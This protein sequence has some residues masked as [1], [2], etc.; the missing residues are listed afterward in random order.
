MIWVPMG[1][2][3]FLTQS[4]EDRSKGRQ[5]CQAFILWLCPSKELVLLAKATF[6]PL[7]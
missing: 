5:R 1:K 6:Q 7:F 4:K 3:A 2:L